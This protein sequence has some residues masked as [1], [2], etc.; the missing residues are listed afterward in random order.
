MVALEALIL[1]CI[2]DAMEEQDV[3]TVDVPGAFTQTDMDELVHVR[4]VGPM[5]ELLERVNP[6]L[7]RKHIVME[8][9]KRVLYA[10]LKK[11]LYGTLRAA[12]L[13]WRDLAKTL[14]SYGFV[15]NPY[16][17]CVANIMID[18][19]QCTVVWHMD[20]LKISHKDPEV[21]S[22]VIRA[23]DKRYGKAKPLIVNRGKVHKYLGMEIDYSE[24]SK[25][26]IRMD[27]YVQKILDKTLE[28]GEGTHTTPA[29]DLLFKV[30]KDGEKLDEKKAEFFHYLTAKLLFLCKRA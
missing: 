26:T 2:I 3:A 23:L 21:V 1:T 18:G 6:K 22:M 8:K 17:R 9:G 16:N 25:V 11:A 13:F 30:N 24:K 20:N 15:I 12:L 28:D 5:V 14:E 27:K 4:L 29:A 7:Y 19:S 10:K